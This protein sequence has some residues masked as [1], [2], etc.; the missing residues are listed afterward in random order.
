[1]SID[2]RVRFAPSP[3]GFPHVGNIRTAL[4]NWLFARH[5]GGV[6]ILRIE[7]TDTARRVEGAVESITDGLRWLGLDWDE[8]PIF[9]SDRL[10]LYQDGIQTLIREGKAYYCFCSAE[11]LQAVREE[12]MHNHLPPRY[13]GHCRNLEETEVQRR[14]AAGEPAVVRFMMPQTGDTTVADLIRGDVTFNNA[15]LNDYVLMKSDGY[16]TYHLANVIDD[17]D[18]RIS[19]VLRADEW[20]SSTPLHVMLYSA[21][22]WSPPVFAHLPMILGPDKAKLSKRHGAT[23]IGE[24][25]DQGYLP[26]AMFNFLALLGWSLDDKTD[27]LTRDQLVQNFSLERVGKTAAVFNKPKLDWM[28]GVYI[29]GLSP[30]EFAA[31][32]LPYIERDLP[33]SVSRP[34]DIEYVARIGTLVQERAKSLAELGELCGFFF[35]E[36]L[37]YPADMLLPKGLEAARAKEI[38]AAVLVLCSSSQEWTVEN[39]ETLVRP[40]C[41]SMEVSTKQLFGL[42]RVATTGRSAAPPLFETMEVLGRDRTLSRLAHAIRLLDA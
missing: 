24:Y 33:A 30:E 22:G 28:N 18:M 6:F 39:L 11:R 14:L 3:T 13:D 1:M 19:H 40:L 38:L 10:H 36:E 21:F 20:I 23:T 41:D 34:L 8:G 26:E 35:Q 42:L 17:H 27:L 29:R 9:Q 15:V 4:F 31:R 25:R 32:A 12:Q 5:H 7:D 37:S 2:V 16:P